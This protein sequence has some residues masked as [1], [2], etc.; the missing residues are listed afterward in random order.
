MVLMFGVVVQPD[1]ATTATMAVSQ[2]NPRL[3]TCSPDRCVDLVKICFTE[4]FTEL[5]SISLYHIS[6]KK[7]IEG[8]LITSILA[9]GTRFLMY[10]YAGLIFPVPVT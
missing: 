5:L 8:Y 1:S 2:T 9:S 4:S 10:S 6:D 3:F 7:S